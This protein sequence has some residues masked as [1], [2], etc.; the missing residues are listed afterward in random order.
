MEQRCDTCWH[1]LR[2]GYELGDHWMAP[3]LRDGV[4]WSECQRVQSSRTEVTES[5]MLIPAPDDCDIRMETAADFGCT[6]W[7]P[8]PASLRHHGSGGSDV[9]L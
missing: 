7:A 2:D 5:L 9:T 3:S 8:R 1:W 4:V 6:E